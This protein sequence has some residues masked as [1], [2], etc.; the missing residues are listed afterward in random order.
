MKNWQKIVL[1]FSL[2]II[3]SLT[4][5]PVFAEAASCTAGPGE[6][7]N[8]L[9]TT[10]LSLII[11]RIIRGV[12]NVLGILALVMFIWGGIQWMT[13]GGSEDKI[14]SGRDT[15][16][17]AALGLALIFASYSILNFVFSIIFRSV[18]PVP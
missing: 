10:D 4:G 7:P 8:P 18:S 12:L 17:W 9:C 5:I 2:I 16:V 13:S 11:G 6:L 14:R 1:S 15:M 3:L